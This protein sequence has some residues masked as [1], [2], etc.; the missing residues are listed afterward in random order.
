MM[1]RALRMAVLVLGSAV[2]G[3]AVMTPQEDLQARIEAKVYSGCGARKLLKDD[4]CDIAQETR[5]FVKQL[6]AEGKN[7]QEILA[8]LEERYGAS[9][10]AI[11]E[12]NWLGRVSYA[13]PYLVAA[14]GLI[15][16]VHFLRRR[17]SLPVSAPDETPR[18]SVTEDLKKEVEQQ[19]LSDL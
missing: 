19:V 11:P 16:V 4:I 7:E 18:P 12:R 1:D 17:A 13:F 3:L 14:V 15:F 9:I 5:A 8:A 2:A 10:L 6:I